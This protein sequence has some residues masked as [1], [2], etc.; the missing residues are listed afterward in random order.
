VRL[1]E[2]RVSIHCCAA[3]ADTADTTDAAVVDSSAVATVVVVITVI[4]PE[5]V[6][7]AICRGVCERARC[8]TVRGVPVTTVK[9][10]RE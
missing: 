5:Q 6:E 10:E 9:T 8:G 4:E 1:T 3:A 2:Q 7:T